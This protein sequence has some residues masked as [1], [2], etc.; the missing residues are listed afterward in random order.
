M[1]DPPAKSVLS[2]FDSIFRVGKR[3]GGNQNSEQIRRVRVSKGD[4]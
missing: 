2:S 4:G 3:R 1:A